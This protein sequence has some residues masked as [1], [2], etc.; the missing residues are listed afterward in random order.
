MAPVDERARHELYERL[1]HAVGEDAT[2]T[3]MSLLPPVGW[4]DVA[5]K[6]DLELLRDSL[7]HRLDAD[8]ARLETSLQR[9]MRQQ[10]FAMLG[11]L[12]TMTGII[13]AFG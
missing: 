3:L 12:F 1:Q 9:E 6:Q 7:G 11:A 5:T 2:E 8:L 4:A 10:L 13:L